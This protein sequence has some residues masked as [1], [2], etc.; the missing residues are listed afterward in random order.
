VLQA[1]KR[2]DYVNES[3]DRTYASLVQAVGERTP[4]GSKLMLLFEH[5]GF[6][7]PRAYEIGTPLFQ[8]KCFTPPESFS[9]PDRIRDVLA[10]EQITHVVMT[11]QPTGPD[12]A[13][14]DRLEPF[15]TGLQKCLDQGQLHVV[16]QSDRYVLL[17]V[18]RK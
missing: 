5:R 18:E 3:T 7:I 14:L 9:D 10:R 6:Y 17:E 13:W 12:Q 16:W 8:A 2:A 4:P 1:I 15:F 11:S